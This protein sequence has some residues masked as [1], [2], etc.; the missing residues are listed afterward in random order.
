MQLGQPVNIVMVMVV[1]DVVILGPPQE[2]VATVALLDVAVVVADLH[3]LRPL[4]RP[5]QLQLRI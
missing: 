5:E 3:F 1:V 2:D 4:Q